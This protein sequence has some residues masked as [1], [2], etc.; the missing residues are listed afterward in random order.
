MINLR[1]FLERQAQALY[2]ARYW[3][4]STLLLPFL[5]ILLPG[6]KYWLAISMAAIFWASLGI[7]VILTYGPSKRIENSLMMESWRDMAPVFLGGYLGCCI[8]ITLALPFMLIA[9][10]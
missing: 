8:L 6:G 3:L 10:H 2:P 1:S 4:V 7:S 5:V 9:L